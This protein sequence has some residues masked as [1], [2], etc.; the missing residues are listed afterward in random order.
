[1]DGFKA[2]K[3]LKE[4]NNNFYESLKSTPI[5]WQYIT[6]DYHLRHVSSILKTREIVDE[7]E[8][9]RYDH[10]SEAETHFLNVY[11]IKIVYA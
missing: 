7:L 8:Q 3:L 5:E 10:I 1:M 9:V 2:A 4:E 11:N 6:N